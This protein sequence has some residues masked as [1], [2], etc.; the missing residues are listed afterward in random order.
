MV[1]LNAKLTGNFVNAVKQLII[2]C[3]MLA[4]SSSVWAAHPLITDDSGTQGKG[5]F[6]LEVNAQYD[7]DTETREGISVK[8]TGRQ[9]AATLSYGIVDTV[10][11]TVGVPYQWVREKDDGILVLNEEGISDTDLEVK[12]RFYE[13]DGLSFALKPGASLPI[14]DDEKGL[15]TGKTGYHIFL[16]C[17]KEAVPWAFHTN[18][19]YIRNENTIEEEVN[20]WHASF[21]ATY[22]VVKDIKLVGDIGLE[23]SPEKGGDSDHAFLIAGAIYSVSENIDIDAGVKYGLTSSETDFSLLA[24]TM[25]RF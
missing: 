9:A 6:Q 3:S 2:I 22:D 19:G 16:I 21:A 13:K 10:D 5:R 18:L 12:W 14:G 25:F 23:K 8:T 20:L 15:G 17:S 4:L 24:G 7:R 11:L 1:G